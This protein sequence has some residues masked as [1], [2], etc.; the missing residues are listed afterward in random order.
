MTMKL[1]AVLSLTLLLTALVRAKDDYCDH[2]CGDVCLS[3][4]RECH[5]DGGDEGDLLWEHDIN[6]YCCVSPAEKNKTNCKKNANT[7]GQ[8][9][10]GQKKGIS[11][12][13]HNQRHLVANVGTSKTFEM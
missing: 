2:L 12:Q 4:S 3:E 7:V 10:G 1:S 5:C 13:C 9:Y 11:E 8:C 6:S